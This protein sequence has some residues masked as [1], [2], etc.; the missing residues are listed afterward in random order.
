MPISDDELI[1]AS[2][3]RIANGHGDVLDKWRVRNADRRE[4]TMMTRNLDTGSDDAWNAWFD[5]RF[6]QSQT[7]PIEEI[8]G[9][10]E[11]IGADTGR[12]RKQLHELELEVAELRG[13]LRGR[14]TGQVVDLPKMVCRR[15][16]DAA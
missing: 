10:A 11:D 16:G 12:L 2:R 4:N 15:H 8:G 6:E 14:R 13:E 9:L 1:A 7:R 5:Q 3:R